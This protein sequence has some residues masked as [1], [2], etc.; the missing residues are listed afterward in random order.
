MCWSNTIRGSIEECHRNG[1]ELD[2]A[3][4]R[5]ETLTLFRR[6]ERMPRK[7]NVRLV[8]VVAFALAAGLAGART[9]TVGS[10]GGYDFAAIQPAI[11]DSNDGDTVVV[12]PGRYYENI[13]FKGRNI[14]LAS[15]D[16]VD[17]NIVATTIIDGNDVKSVVTFAGTEN[18]SCVLRGF[19]ITDGYA[20]L[21]GGV[22]GNGTMAT[23][24]NNVIV[25]NLVEKPPP[26]LIPQCY[27][28]GLCDCDGLIQNNI[29]TGNMTA[30]MG[31]GGGLFDC[32]G[33]IRNNVIS[34]N[35]ADCGGGLRLCNG[36]ILNNLLAGNYGVYGGA[37]ADC[38]GSIINCTIVGNNPDGFRNCGGTIKNCIIWYNDADGN[39]QLNDCN[40][41]S[42][43]CI[44][45]WAGGGVG[46]VSS[47]PCFV[48]LGY[49]QLVDEGG[50][51]WWKWV[52]DDSDYHLKSEAGRWD[53]NQ[54]QWLTDAN[55]SRCI[56]AGDPNSDWTAELWPHGKRINI[57][58]YGGT[59]QASMSQSPAG[60]IADLNNNA[61]V[62][63]EDLKLLLDKWLN[64]RPLL[65][66]DLD[67]DG[68]VDSTDYTLFAQ[69]WLWE[70]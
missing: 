32:D 3:E 45:S 7:A 28:A 61:Y 15:I 23:I 52:D 20:E 31:H 30:Y 58:A 50:W 33:T 62:N 6:G 41:P 39:D 8:I 25:G 68:F 47:D 16:P 21:G 13:N 67:R 24:E 38:N 65:T 70:E 11:D 34:D 54:N 17:Q 42:Y 66:E 49:W 18:S 4:G 5:W 44:H 10:G 48:N 37:F 46:N 53:P 35:L 36:I 22:C 26:P 51:W 56:D 57:G 1:R 19:T 9:I 63:W 2:P 64:D 29:V 55:T 59:P 14:V 12:G 43:S 40:T 27:G 60:N 69:N